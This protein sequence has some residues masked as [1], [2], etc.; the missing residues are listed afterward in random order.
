MVKTLNISFEEEKFRALKRAKQDM[1]L[2]EG[3]KIA[4]ELFVLKL[5]EN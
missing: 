1:E 3:H 4:W 2:K 5:V